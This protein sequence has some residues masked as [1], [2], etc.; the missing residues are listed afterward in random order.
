MDEGRCPLF[1]GGRQFPSETEG[2]GDALFACDDM[3][4]PLD[5]QTALI[6]RFMMRLTVIRVVMCLTRGW[7][8]VQA[9]RGQPTASLKMVASQ[10]RLYPSIIYLARLGKY[11]WVWL[12][13]EDDW[14]C[15]IGPLWVSALG[16]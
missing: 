2:E 5:N 3:F 14:V 11:C 15:K 6:F 9:E 16:L 4:F 7:L 8:P 10:D 12:V 1:M 13:N